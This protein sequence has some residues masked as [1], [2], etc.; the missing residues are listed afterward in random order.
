MR[1]IKVIFFAVIFLSFNTN[2]AN[3]EVIIKKNEDSSRE[4]NIKFTFESSNSVKKN[5][6][7]LSNFKKIDRFNPSLVEATIISKDINEVVLKTLFRDCVL[8]FCR[9]MIMYESILSYCIDDN[10]CVIN[11]EVI[12]NVKSPI[13]SGQTSWTIKSSKNIDSSQID[14]H[15]SFSAN[16][17]LPPF[18]GESIF[19]KTINRNLMFLKDT[20]GKY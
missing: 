1:K 17:S 9:D 15:S 11:A 7:L 14:Y 13:K 16:I 18:F 10:H 2:A 6:R 5:F 20:I 3:S 19:K 8:F 12:P 4:F